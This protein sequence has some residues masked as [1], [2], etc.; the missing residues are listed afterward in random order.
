MVTDIEDSVDA[1]ERFVYHQPVYNKM[2]NA[3][4]A[5]QLY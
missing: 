1:N 2:L 4:V 3:E 5:L